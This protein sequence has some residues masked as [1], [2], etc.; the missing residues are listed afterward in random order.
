MKRL[1][2]AAGLMAGV[3]SAGEQTL[4]QKMAATAMKLWPDSTARWG[5]EPAVALRGIDE[6]WKQT[7]DK[8]YFSYIQKYLDRLID[9]DGNMKGYRPEEFQLDHILDGRLAL[10][11][12]KVT[13]AEKYYKA[14]VQLR[15]QLK[16]QPRVPE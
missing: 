10:M 2:L 9:K 12:Y 7:A 4:S 8:Q 1:F 13:K 16:D 3:I 11:L 6:V 5:Y 14:V 15:Q